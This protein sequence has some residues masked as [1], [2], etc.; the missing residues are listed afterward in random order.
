MKLAIFSDLHN[1]FTPWTP[2]ET[3]KKAD[4]VILAGDIDVGVKGVLWAAKTFSQ[5]VVYVPGNHEY[6]KGVYQ[7]VLKKMREAVKLMSS[8]D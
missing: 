8:Y 5:P 6:Y 7:T 3:V 2:P 4:V 1:E